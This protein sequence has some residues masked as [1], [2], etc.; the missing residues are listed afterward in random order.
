MAIFK[1]KPPV[2]PTAPLEEEEKL[3]EQEGQEEESEQEEEQ[4]AAQP[5]TKCPA[6][7]GGLVW[8]IPL[9]K[10]VMCNNCNGK[11]QLI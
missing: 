5:T 1:K 3:E 4:A 8:D 6:C 9:K 10:W 11:G 7:D 2:D